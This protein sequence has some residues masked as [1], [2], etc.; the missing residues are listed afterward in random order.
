MELQ[1]KIHVWNELTES[2]EVVKRIME[3]NINNKLDHY[4]N[5]FEK[6]NAEGTIELHC[7]KNKKWL[8]DGKFQA[9]LDWQYFRYEREDYKNLDDLINHLCDHF[10]EELSTVG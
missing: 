7:N 2:K 3:E 4:L 6:D 10:K 5:K 8:F 1:I 9:N